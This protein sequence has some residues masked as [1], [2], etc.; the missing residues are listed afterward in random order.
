MVQGRSIEALF[1]VRKECISTEPSFLWVGVLH[2]L[3]QKYI[4]SFGA[5]YRG[6]YIYNVLSVE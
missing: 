2:E 4:K 6:I 3:Y 1:C 5:Y